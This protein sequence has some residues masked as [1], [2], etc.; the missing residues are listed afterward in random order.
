MKEQLNLAEDIN[1]VSFIDLLT[2]KLLHNAKLLQSEGFL[3]IK[4]SINQRLEFK[5]QKVNIFDF[6]LEKIQNSGTFVGIN[7]F[8]HALLKQENG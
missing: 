8:G 6:K 1:V 7:E 5:D 3:A 4:D 2:Q